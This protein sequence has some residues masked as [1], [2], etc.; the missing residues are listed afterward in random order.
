MPLT[1]V[2]ARVSVWPAML[3]ASVPARG[4]VEIVIAGRSVRVGVTAL[5]PKSR[6]CDEKVGGISAEPYTAAV[7][8]SRLASSGET[9][10]MSNLFLSK[11]ETRPSTICWPAGPASSF[12]NAIGKCRK[13]V[14]GFRMPPR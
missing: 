8:S 1:T 7:S 10:R 6:S 9:T 14:M 11:P 5:A 12:T 4:F 2:S 13:L 3:A